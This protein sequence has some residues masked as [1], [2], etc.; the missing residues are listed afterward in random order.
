M[1]EI[2]TGTI[3][4][5]GVY[6][7]ELIEAPR[8]NDTHNRWVARGYRWVPSRKGWEAKPKLYGWDEAHNSPAPSPAS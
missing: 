6:H 3:I 1:S 2:T 7:I 5:N 4:N 8:W